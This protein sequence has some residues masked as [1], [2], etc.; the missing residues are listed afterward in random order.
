[1]TPTGLQQKSFLWRIVDAN[2]I[3]DHIFE[4]NYGLIPLIVLLIAAF[5]FC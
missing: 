5:K 4:Q 3:V 2:F 1:M